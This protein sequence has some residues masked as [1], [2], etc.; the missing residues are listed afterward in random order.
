VSSPGSASRTAPQSPA[1]R[2][3]EA[4]AGQIG[5]EMAYDSD[6][7]LAVRLRFPVSDG[8]GAAD[9]AAPLSSV[10]VLA[11]TGKDIEMNWQQVEGKWDQIRGSVQKQWGKLTDHDLA[12]A[13]G[14]RDEFVGRVKER[15]GIAK[16]EAEKQVDDFMD[17]Q[18]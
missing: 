3:I 16:E 9:P 4:F 1:K 2:I 13:R 7:P 6:D 11:R 18:N 8:P 14:S 5:A 15:Y 12:R 10:R 17:R